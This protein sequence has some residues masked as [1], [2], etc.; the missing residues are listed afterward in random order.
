MSTVWILVFCVVVSGAV[1]VLFV[2]ILAVGAH[3]E[4]NARSHRLG[5]LLK[6]SHPEWN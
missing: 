4:R 6:L 5:R 1:T 2:A 3:K